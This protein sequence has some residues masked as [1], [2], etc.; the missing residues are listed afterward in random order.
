MAVKGRKG[1][2]E[3]ARDEQ[4]FNADPSRIPT[5]KPAFR[6]T[7][8]VT[9]ANSSSISDG[10]AA[11]VLMRASEAKRRKLAPLARIVGVATHAQ[12]PAWFTTAPVGAMRKL[13]SATG[14]KAGDVALYEINEAFAVVTLAAMRDLDL[15]QALPGRHAHAISRLTRGRRHRL[16]A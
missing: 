2:V 10:A 3:V 16:Q 15:P 6:D 7:G 1:T 5:L 12:A 8:T 4:P 13:L 9:A 14:W 11:L